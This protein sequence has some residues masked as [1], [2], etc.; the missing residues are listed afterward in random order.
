MN[1]VQLS[2][3]ALS[4]P[5]MSHFTSQ[6][7]LMV[8]GA[9]AVRGLHVLGHIGQEVNDMSEYLDISEFFQSSVKGVNLN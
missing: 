2:A 1:P 9:Q 4:D 8:A 7:L 6:Y 3:V 5:F